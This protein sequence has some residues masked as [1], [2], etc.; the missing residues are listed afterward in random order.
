[1]PLS[2]SQLTRCWT[3]VLELSKLAPGENVL[4]LT[5]QNSD[6]RVVDAA[7]R[8][9]AAL[10]ARVVKLDI[11]PNWDTCEVGA[12]PTVVSGASP[13]DD[14]PM[15]L[16][17]MKAADLV[18]DTVFLLFTPG[19]R[20]VLESG[21]RMLLAYEPPEVL[22]RVMPS[23]DD[24]RRVLAARDA[25]ARGRRITVT[26]AAGTRLTASIGAYPIT[27]EYGYVDSPGRWDHWPSGFVARLPDD[28]TAEGVVVLAPGDIIL[29]FKNYVQSPITLEIE[30]GTIVRISGGLDAEFLDTYLRGFDDPDAY[31]VSHL[32]WGLQ[33]KARW[34]SLGLYDKAA[35]IGMEARSFYGNFLFSTGP[36]GSRRTK[37]HLDIP[38]RKCSFHVDGQPMVVDGDVVAP[39]Q[40]VDGARPQ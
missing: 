39:D 12:D 6:P 18:I 3:E 2:P 32:G 16:A 14:D 22:A 15:A 1:M 35:T 13:I 29:P 8:A 36:G 26:S 4:I 30:R 7:A 19:Q 10:Q 28:G 37:A 20:A 31:A 9:A 21:T 23:P 25:Y 11:A 5:S 33:P 40:R 27:A 24:R 17:A 34:T 38:M